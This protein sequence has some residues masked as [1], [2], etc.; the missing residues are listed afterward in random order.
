MVEDAARFGRCQDPRRGWAPPG[1]RPPVASPVIRESVY[2]VAARSPHDGTLVSLVRPVARTDALALCLA[3]LSRRHPDERLLLVVEGAGWQWATAL[4]R[5]A[6]IRLIAQP[7]HS[8]ELNPV[9][10]R[11]EER[12]EKW[13]ANARFTSLDA[14]E[15]RLVEALAAL[16]RDPTRVASLAGFDGG[17]GGGEA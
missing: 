11:W 3:A 7:P 13:F 10:H 8:P 12:R 16:E 1:V 14:V 6:T 17:G 15:D 4:V 9:E 5:P 2:A